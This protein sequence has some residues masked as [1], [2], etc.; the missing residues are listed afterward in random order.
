MRLGIVFYLALVFEND[1]V[2]QST[3]KTIY[4]LMYAALEKT[5]RFLEF[6]S[7]LKEEQNTGS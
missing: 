5:N 4:A 1:G 3:T 2:F 7:K 6:F